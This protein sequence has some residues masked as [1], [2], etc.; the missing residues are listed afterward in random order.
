MEK[1]GYLVI[2]IT[3][4]SHDEARKIA[5]ALVSQ[6]KAACVNIVPR[7]N[8]LFWWE[9]KLE[10]DEESLLLVKTRAELF[11]EVMNLVREIHSYEVP[12]IIALPV[13][14]GNPDYLAWL[15][16]ETGMR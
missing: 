6:R 10:E 9:N 14:E 5:D 12:E 13:I 11:P 4:G 1:A 7:V 8:S 16:K 2:L 3:A 15:D